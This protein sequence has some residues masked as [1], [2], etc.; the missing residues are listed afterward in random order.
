MKAGEIMGNSDTE[1]LSISLKVK[2]EGKQW[3][4]PY[5]ITGLILNLLLNREMGGGGVES[6]LFNFIS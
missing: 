3:L 5:G 4:M 6:I 2:G 1:G